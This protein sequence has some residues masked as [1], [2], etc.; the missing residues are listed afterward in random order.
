MKV[1]IIGCDGQLGTDIVQIM[2]RVS[3]YEVV[4]LNHARLDVTDAYAVQELMA[5]ERPEVVVNCAAFHQV[6]MCEDHPEEA[7]RVNA[8]GVLH[9]A[10]A[11]AAIDAL[12]VYISTDYVFDG[13]KGRPYIEEDTPRPI[14]VY[15]ASKL[16]GE[17]LV[18]QICPRW[19]IVRVASLF[20]KAGAR[21]KGGNFVESVLRRAEAG[22][23]LRVVDDVRMSPTYTLDAA[24]GLDRLIRE[25]ATGFIHLTNSGSCSWSEFAS[26]VV[27]LAGL[28]SKVES[29]AASQYPYKAPRPKDSSLESTRHELF[30]AEPLR[31]W[32]D[33]LRAYMEEKSHIHR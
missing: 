23:S 30:M 17:F 15:G 33:A 28:S 27:Q 9:I 16:A 12:C 24:R 22:E 3:D 1:A 2:D 7:F 14:N 20:G 11:C 31:P 4:S 32:K 29:I 6:D 19:L 21:G 18:R 10:K 5:A 25:K 26:S 8:I 13:A